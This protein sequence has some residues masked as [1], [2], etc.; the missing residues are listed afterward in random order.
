MVN[1]RTF[2]R[3]AGVAAAGGAVTTGTAAA[4]RGGDA[5]SDRVETAD[6]S[7]FSDP[8]D[9]VA[10]AA[11]SWVNHRFGWV[12]AYGESSK[13]DLERYLD[14]VDLTVRIDGEEIDDPARYWGEFERNDEGNWIVWWSYVTPPKSPDLY[15]FEVVFAYPD[16]YTDGDLVIEPGY[17]R[18]WAGY[19]EVV[20]GKGR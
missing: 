16:G 14:A 6:V 5:P 10:V 9:P 7:I 15:E 13:A 3:R 11:G 17:E 18:A 20:A 19:Y 8:D 1:R 2:L 4:R 12:D